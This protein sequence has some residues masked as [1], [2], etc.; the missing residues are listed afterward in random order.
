[1]FLL[2]HIDNIDYE[3]ISTTPLCSSEDR[4]KLNQLRNNILKEAKEYNNLC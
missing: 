1:M 4:S 2:N 3:G